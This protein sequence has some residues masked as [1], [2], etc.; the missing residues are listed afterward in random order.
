MKQFYETYQGDEKLAALRRELSW[1]HNVSIFSRCKIPEER[2]FYLQLSI[3]EKY[4][5][6]ELDR[7][8]SS[9]VFER[10]LLGNEKLS[11]VLR[12]LPQPVSG[13]FRDS[14]VFEFLNLPKVHTEEDLQKALI[15]SLKGF[16]LEIGRDFSFIGQDYRLQVGNSDFYA[17]LLFYHRELRCLVVFE[18]KIDRFKPEYMGQLEFYLEALDRDVRK[19]HENPSIG[20]LMCREK[21]D[22]VVEYAL[23]RSLSPT[24]I[25]EYETKL[26][27]KEILRQKINDFYMLLENQPGEADDFIK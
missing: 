9:G 13:A 5:V 21:D 4:S 3:K 20:V 17:D 10:T 7:Q 25:T 19:E 8:I 14:Y 27:P 2:K 1:S 16:I 12:E 18:L 23:S 26:I 24:V 6:R 15:N 11:T 22:E